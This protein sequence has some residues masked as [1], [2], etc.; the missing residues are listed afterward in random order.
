MELLNAEQSPTLFD[1]VI[2]NGRETERCRRQA[3]HLPQINQE[4]TMN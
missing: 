1:V 2:T 4:M 3:L